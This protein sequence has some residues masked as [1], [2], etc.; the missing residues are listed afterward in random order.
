MNAEQALLIAKRALR[1]VVEL[2]FEED[3]AK[4]H[5]GKLTKSSSDAIDQYK[6]MV[7]ICEDA[8][9]NINLAAITES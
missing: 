2:D 1:K 4:Y 3:L 8:L 7:R 9:S 6:E 5:Y